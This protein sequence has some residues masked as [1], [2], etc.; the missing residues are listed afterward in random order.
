MQRRE[1]AF[2][3]VA[4]FVGAAP[5]D[6]PTS[7]EEL[8]GD[9]TPVRS[10]SAPEAPSVVL[11]LGQDVW[12]KSI[13]AWQQRS[14]NGD[15]RTDVGCSLEPIQYGFLQRCDSAFV[16][17]WLNWVSRKPRMAFVEDTDAPPV[18]KTPEDDSRVE[19][20]SQMAAVPVTTDSQKGK[21]RTAVRWGTPSDEGSGADW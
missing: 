6:L 3:S 2:L 16:P 5:T 14:D 10:E 17:A 11:G 18:S 4:L 13:P 21:R 1:A 20:A 8:I 7:R 19:F 12:V 15:F 9:S